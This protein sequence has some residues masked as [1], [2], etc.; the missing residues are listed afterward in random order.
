[1]LDVVI[2][3]LARLT[4]SAHEAKTKLQAAI[5][6]NPAEYEIVH[7][8]LSNYYDVSNHKEIMHAVASF[9]PQRERATFRTAL[10]TL[11]RSQF[12]TSPHFRELVFSFH[13]GVAQGLS[14]ATNAAI[15]YFAHFEELR[16]FAQQGR[17][18]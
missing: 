10:A 15:I 11:L 8:D 2:S 18:T 3:R 14:F 1:V 17:T 5:I 16:A 6:D 4:S 12:V 9:L 7:Y 13:T